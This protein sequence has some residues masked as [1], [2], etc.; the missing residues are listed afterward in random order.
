[1]ARGSSAYTRAVGGI[2]FTT[3]LGAAYF[4]ASVIHAG[5]VAWAMAFS[6][7]Y[8]GP[9]AARWADSGWLAVLGLVVFFAVKGL[10]SALLAAVG[11]RLVSRS[12]RP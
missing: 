5:T 8:Y 10:V 2:A 9:E 7:T 1:M 6:A 11:L 3:G 4:V 12:L